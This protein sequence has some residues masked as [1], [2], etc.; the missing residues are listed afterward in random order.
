MRPLVRLKIPFAVRES[1]RIC[2][3]RSAAIVLVV[4]GACRVAVAEC[5]GERVRCW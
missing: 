5:E 1:S 2:V 3:W 4:L